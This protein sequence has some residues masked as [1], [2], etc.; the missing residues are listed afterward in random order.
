MPG[1]SPPTGLEVLDEP[2]HLT[3]AVPPASPTGPF[4]AAVPG[5]LG[6]A[7]LRSGVVLAAVLAVVGPSSPFLSTPYVLAIVLVGLLAGVPGLLRSGRERGQTVR[8]ALGDGKLLLETTGPGGSRQESWP[9]DQVWTAPEGSSSVQH[10]PG[11]PVPVRIR[12]GPRNLDCLRYHAPGV[13]LVVHYKLAGR[14]GFQPGTPPRDLS[15]L[16]EEPPAKTSGW[17]P[18]ENLFQRAWFPDPERPALP[19][20]LGTRVKVQQHGP[21]HLSFRAPVEGVLYTLG[22]FVVVPILVA[23]LGALIGSHFDFLP[24][25]LLETAQARPVV[26]RTVC[27]AIMVGMVFAGRDLT[28]RIAGRK[29]LRA[30]GGRLEIGHRGY[31]RDEFLS[32]GVVGP[33]D[34][35]DVARLI[36][37]TRSSAPK[38]VLAAGANANF[39]TEDDLLWLAD[40]LQRSLVA[41]R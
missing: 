21:E 30:E 2:S 24:P 20:P 37:W 39:T 18:G 3:I 4:R 15:Q 31:D 34:K 40:A 29:T 16:I 6:W 35:D 38:F 8:L 10:A 36:L 14:L 23:S 5:F 41:G 32:L 28:P 33:R 1:T 25:G 27:L 26:W 9:L 19:A 11:E 17:F 13:R 22:M 7:A 12:V